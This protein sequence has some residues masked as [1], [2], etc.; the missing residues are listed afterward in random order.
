M[1]LH[2]NLPT[3]EASPFLSVLYI[4]RLHIPASYFFQHFEAC[5][6]KPCQA[7]FLMIVS[8]ISILALYLF[9]E[10]TLCSGY[11]ALRSHAT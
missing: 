7:E 8:I 9:D 6:V 10:G 1:N 3:F 11:D 4:E 2:I 5:G